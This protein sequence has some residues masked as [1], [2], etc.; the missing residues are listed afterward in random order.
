MNNSWPHRGQERESDQNG[1]PASRP[2]D[3]PPP[4]EH[5]RLLPNRLDSTP[6]LSPDDPAVSP[7]NLFSV[8]AIR[9]ATVVLTC[10]T[11]IWWALMLISFFI[12]PPGLHVRGSPFFA[13]SYASIAFLTLAV[14]LL[15]FAVPSRS[16]RV[17][18]FAT[19]VCRSTLPSGCFASL[20]RLMPRCYART[21][22]PECSWPSFI[23]EDRNLVLT[24]TLRSVT[25]GYH[26]DVGRRE[27]ST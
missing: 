4:D 6:Y 20:G 10:L 16:A 14:E 1:T 15:F 9:L 7:Y 27:D 22:L 26:C 21:F 19:A 24:K 23:S 2:S 5:T 8:R 13:F 3:R 17:L 12:T 18:S 25:C 11:F